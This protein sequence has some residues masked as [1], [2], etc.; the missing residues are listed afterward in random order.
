MATT[1]LLLQ[2]AIQAYKER[3]KPTTHMMGFFT[4]KTY[5]TSI[6]PLAVQRANGMAAV[7]VVRGTNGNKNQF[8]K[9][10]EKEITPPEYHET[11]SI[12]AL[13]SYSRG[14]GGDS[15]STPTSVQAEIA[16]E[17]ADGII[18]LKDMIVRAQEIQCVQALETGIVTLKNADSIDYKRKA[19]S[20]LDGSA[21]GGYWISETCPIEKQLQ[22]VGGFIREEGANNATVIDATMSSNAWIALQNTKYFKDKANFQQV[23]LLAIGNPTGRNGANFHGQI[24]AGSFIFRIWTYDATYTTLV[25]GVE[26]QTRLTDET[27]VVFTP[28][29]GAKFEMAY[30]AVDT[31]VKSNGANAMSGLVIAKSMADYF[32]WDDLDT[33]SRS[34]DI[35]IV[36]SPIARLIT[37][38]MV[39]TLKVADT[40]AAPI[41][42]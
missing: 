21:I 18:S 29:E 25:G 37:V 6:I 38:D 16:T 39:V 2:A 14:F 32:V 22:R 28:V 9:W 30:G 36:S 7:D 42:E 17:I 40:F 41:A 13:R 12:N 26:T 35:H 15:N 10:S 8:S 5:G 3:R 24:T 31:I 23:T 20:L 27:K 34:H 1:S 4:E 11:F 33:K 19:D